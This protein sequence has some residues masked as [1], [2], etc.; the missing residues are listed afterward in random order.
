VPVITESEILARLHEVTDPELSLPITELGMVR[1]AAVH[2][3]AAIVELV[4][5]FLG[6]P[7]RRFIERDVRARL[8]SVDGVRDVEV[9]WSTA[10]SWTAGDIT[11]TG[12][13]ALAEF[14]VAVPEADG[15]IHCP[16][17]GGS[18]VVVDSEFGAALC[19]RLGHCQTCG[20]PV[21]MMRVRSA[22]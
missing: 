11:A 13:A 21:E 15:T 6:C 22:P 3:D 10:Y 16:Y 12:R 14:G 2:G 20:D 17:C 4:P 7:A 18:D 9:S 19:R 5:T 1:S 8:E